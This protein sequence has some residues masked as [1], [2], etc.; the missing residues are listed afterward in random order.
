MIK[1]KKPFS[2]PSRLIPNYPGEYSWEDW[3]EETRSK[4][5][6]QYFFRETIP[7]FFDSLRR[8][9]SNTYWWFAH[10]VTHRYHIVKLSNPGGG[11]EYNVGWTD[12]STRLLMFCGLTIVNFVEKEEPFG[13]IDTREEPWTSYAKEWQALY[14]WWKVERPASVKALDEELTR[15]AALRKANGGPLEPRADNY[16]KLERA[17]EERDTEMMIRLIKI[18]ETMWT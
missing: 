1:Y 12:T 7:D 13:H 17:L 18:R 11:V 9:F 16:T 3:E 14:D 6:I 8:R 5:P 4:Y 10:R 2:L 15:W